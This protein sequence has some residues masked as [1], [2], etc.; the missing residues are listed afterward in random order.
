[1]SRAPSPTQVPPPVPPSR[2][3]LA[4]LGGFAA[5]VVRRFFQDGMTQAAGALT[6]STLL[7]LVPLAVIAFAVLAGF[8]AFEEVRGELQAFFFRALVPEAGAELQRYFEAFTGNARNLTAAGTAALALTAVLLLST[9][10]T[11]LNRVWRVERPRPWLTRILIFWAVLTLGPLLI[12]VSFTFTSDALAMLRRWGAGAEVIGRIEP[13]AGVAGLALGLL[14][15][16][17]AFTLIFKLVPARRVRLADAA[18]GGAVAGL[19]F[20]LLRWAFDAY[21]SSGTTYETIYGAVAVVPIF[22]VWLYASWTVVILGAVVA[23]AFPDWWRSRDPLIG[24]EMTPALRLEIA[25]AVLSVLSARARTGGAVAPGM[26]KDRVPVE[27]REEIVD[28]LALAGYVVVTEDGALAL[29]RDLHAT[30][31]GDLVADLGLSL[32]A[33]AA[34]A[35]SE[36]QALLQRQSGT[37]PE[38]LGQL[39]KAEAGVL[40][41]PLAEV[42]AGSGGG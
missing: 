28:R 15:Q 6:Y 22:L 1:M 34:A 18:L 13:G 10:E 23:A 21:L 37:L 4:G 17:L 11:T 42:V 12:G 16:I 36:A 26:L 27:A 14:S 38:L 20:H 41:R 19:L 39:E 5:H 2:G 31:L 7:A 29:A 32:T 40:D 3:A 35:R 9:I 24:V 33:G 30:T 8:P 25:V